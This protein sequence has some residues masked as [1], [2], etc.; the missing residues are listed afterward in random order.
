MKIIIKSNFQDF[1]KRMNE[2][3]KNIRKLLPIHIFRALTLIEARMKQ[4]IRS[5]LNVITGTLLNSVQKE[6]RVNGDGSIEGSVGPQN[7]PYAGVQ[8][9]GHTFPARFIKP[10]NKLALKWTA[11]GKTFFSKGHEIPSFTVKGVRYMRDAI[12][13]SEKEIEDELKL[14][15]E[16]ALV[17]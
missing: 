12:D 4:N 2:S 9:F 8:E 14:F 10:R 16:K 5:R 17:E 7:V 15:L 11:N 1:A 13:Q 3:P 6:M